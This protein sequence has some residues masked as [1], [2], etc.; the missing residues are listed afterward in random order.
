MSRTARNANLLAVIIPFIAF[1]AALVLLWNRAVGPLDLGILAVLYLLSGVGVTVGFHRL[2]THRAFETHRPLKYVLAV[3]GSLSVQ[4]PVITWVADHRKHHAHPDQEGDPH[5]PHVGH[6]S[7]LRGLLHAHVGWLMNSMGRAQRRRYAP[8]LMEDPGM[9][10]INRSF[11]LIVVAGLAIPFALGYLIGGTLTA[12]LTALLWGGLVRIFL[13]HHV[14]WSINSVCHFFGRRR[15]AT[16]DHSTNVF[17]LALPSL[18]ESWHHN[19]HAF[20]RA[21][22]HGLRRWEVDPSGALIGLLERVGLAWNVVRITPERQR[23][24]EAPASTRIAA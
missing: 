4:G 10:A 2:L 1:L 9:R 7:G 16:E 15:F 23:Q 12:A 11:E 14:T 22:Q 21:A 6:G 3:L 8:E 5:S 20:P 24:R 19:H 18:G 13:L 17:W